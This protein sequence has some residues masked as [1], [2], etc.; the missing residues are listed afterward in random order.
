M[1]ESELH[2]DRPALAGVVR[3]LEDQE[4]LDEFLAT[5]PG[6]VTTR[7]R[8]AIGLVVRIIMEKHGWRKTGRKGSLDRK[9]IR[10]D[11]AFIRP[12]ISRNRLMVRHINTV[13]S[14]LIDSQYRPA[15]IP[16]EQLDLGGIH[17]LPA[18][19]LNRLGDS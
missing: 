13:L 11:P 9:T 12:S 5:T 14:F 1:V 2:H 3:E 6:H 15:R 18:T 19:V 7:F 8:Q 16:I 10:G 17:P 4:G